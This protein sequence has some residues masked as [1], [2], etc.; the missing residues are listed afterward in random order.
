MASASSSA[1]TVVML[2]LLLLL[3]P[4]ILSS[5]SL[6][7]ELLGRYKTPDGKYECVDRAKVARYEFEFSFDPKTTSVMCC[8]E[9]APPNHHFWDPFCK[10][11][12]QIPYDPSQQKGRYE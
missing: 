2:L 6:F 5:L 11:I 12:L 3:V 4:R 1:V 9:D 10:E 8:E 7:N